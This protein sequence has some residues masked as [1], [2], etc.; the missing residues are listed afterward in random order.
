MVL[1]ILT[2][3]LT[4]TPTLAAE[5]PSGGGDQVGS[6]TS[7]RLD[8]F[9]IGWLP[10][11]LGALVS[12]FTYDWEDVTHRSRVWEGGPDS[13]GAYH[14]DLMIRVLRGRPLHDLS[15]LRDYLARYHEI[16]PD[17]W[18]LKPFRHHGHPGY[19]GT[20]VAFWLEE[21][22]VAVELKTYSDVVSGS[23]LIRTAQAIHPAGS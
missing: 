13:T 21:P 19:R 8:G 4:T 5:S 14:V 1:A 3:L 10:A 15:S 22:G 11:G 6:S 20:D 7:S 12:D 2:A 23:D 16:D 9:E 17:E 18:Q